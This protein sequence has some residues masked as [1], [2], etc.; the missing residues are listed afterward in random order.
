MR[1]LTH[2]QINF[3]QNKHVSAFHFSNYC[4]AWKQTY[5]THSIRMG[6]Q[7][8]ACQFSQLHLPMQLLNQTRVIF[9]FRSSWRL[10]VK[11]FAALKYFSKHFQNQVPSARSESN[12]FQPQFLMNPNDV[13]KWHSEFIKIHLELKKWCNIL[14]CL[15]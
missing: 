4:F 15:P 3:P 12:R 1:P 8:L 6:I 2:F 13:C 5:G 14:K 9:I 7:T 10:A 11:Q